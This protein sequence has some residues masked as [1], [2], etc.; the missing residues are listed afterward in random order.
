MV[1]RLD[2]PAMVAGPGAS[3]AATGALAS[4]RR[5]RARFPVAPAEL[6]AGIPLD[7]ALTLAA[8]SL[9]AEGAAEL[10]GRALAVAEGGRLG[11][12]GP[13]SWLF[14]AFVVTLLER[15]W[16]GGRLP[17]A[18]ERIAAY[19]QRS[20]ECSLRSARFI[21]AQAFQLAIG[22]AVGGFVLAEFTV[23]WRGLSQMPF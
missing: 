7:R 2:G 1:T 22:I 3:A 19:N 21:L 15:A 8:A 14:D 13:A 18:L 17:D 12:P 23:Y 4:A 11:A 16:G 9:P 6:R 10:R 5:S 20:F